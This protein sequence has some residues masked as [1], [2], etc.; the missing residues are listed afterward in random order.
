M[1]IWQK[2]GPPQDGQRELAFM[3]DV[4]AEERKPKSALKRFGAPKN[5]NEELFN[6]QAEFYDKGLS[7]EAFWKMWTVA[8]KVA[9]RLVRSRLKKDRRRFDDD[10]VSF[11]AA[12]AVEYVL[13]RF[14]KEQGYVVTTNWITALEA[15]VRHALDYAK[16][17][18]KLVD[19]VPMEALEAM[20]G[21]EEF[22]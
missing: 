16:E 6:L 17:A 18:D 2:G 1:N 14:K 13:R 4:R 15:G 22:L 19:F 3:D 7:D 10:F 5:D 21:R 20:A 9:L 11:K 8:E 12:E